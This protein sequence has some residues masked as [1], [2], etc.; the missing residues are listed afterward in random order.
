MSTNLFVVIV[1]LFGAIVHAADFKAAYVDIQ[2]AVT[3]VEE[4]K[5]AKQRLQSMADQ[6][7]KGFEKEQANLKAEVEAFQKQS[8]TMADEPRRTKEAELQK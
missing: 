7:Q 5:A 1:T 8:P 2:R 6:K 3:E 4:G